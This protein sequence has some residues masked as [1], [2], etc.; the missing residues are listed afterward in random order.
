MRDLL[1]FV[2]WVAVRARQGSWGWGGMFV[3]AGELNACLSLLV[4]VF[5]PLVCVMN[6]DLL[7]GGGELEWISLSF[8]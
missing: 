8:C 6:S 3:G 1:L 2:P 4:I 5:F 7:D